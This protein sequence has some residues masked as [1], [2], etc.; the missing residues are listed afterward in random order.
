M[1]R[2]LVLSALVIWCSTGVSATERTIV[3]IPEVYFYASSDQ[4]YC[5][6]RVD[7]HNADI[8]YRRSQFL[9]YIRDSYG[10]TGHWS[11]DYILTAIDYVEFSYFH[12]VFYQKCE[13]P[14]P[15]LARVS[16]YFSDC[17]ANPSLDCEKSKPLFTIERDSPLVK[18]ITS[19]PI[20]IV[21]FESIRGREELSSCIIKVR[22]QIPDIRIPEKLSEFRSLTANL[23]LLS[24][25]YRISIMEIRLLND[26]YYI[27]LSRQCNQKASLFALMLEFLDAEN[28]DWAN[29]LGHPDFA[30]NISELRFFETGKR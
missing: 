18:V 30:P 6:V 1:L 14:N 5:V 19:L 10:R 20:P 3:E 12:I 27:L 17:D 26:V 11:K 9:E 29:Y 25:K 21:L 13:M 7:L 28:L 15:T 8:R 2:T 23:D 24:T 16:S 4:Q 22:A